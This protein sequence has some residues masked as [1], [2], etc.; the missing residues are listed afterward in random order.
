MRLWYLRRAIPWVVLA[1]CGTVAALMAAAVQ[2]W[3]GSVGTLA[4]Y[5]LA[6]CAAAA[7]FLMDE[8][9]SAVVRVT[10]RGGAWRV[11][12][13]LTGLAL[14]IALWVALVQGLPDDAGTDRPSLTLAG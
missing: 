7:G 10:P 13:R 11:L 9:S 8:S 6:V 1:G 4:P 3:P 2:R 12:A 5:M 14:P